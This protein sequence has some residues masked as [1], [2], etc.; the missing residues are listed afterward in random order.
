MHAMFLLMAVLAWVVSPVEQAIAV[1][2]FY[3]FH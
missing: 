2:A 1:E 3:C